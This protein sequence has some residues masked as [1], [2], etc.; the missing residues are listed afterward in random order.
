[1]RGFTQSLRTSDLVLMDAGDSAGMRVS[2]AATIVAVALAVP[3]A[4]AASGT[5]GRRS[6]VTAA[7]YAAG[8]ARGGERLHAAPAARR[9]PDSLP[10][11]LVP[12]AAGALLVAVILARRRS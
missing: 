10:A 1:M 9:P 7:T 12:A 8:S 4:A 3:A 2:A 5:D 6:R 11:W